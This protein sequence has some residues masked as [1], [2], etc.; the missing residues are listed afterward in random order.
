MLIQGVPLATEPSISLIILTPIWRAGFNPVWTQM[1]ATCSTYYDVV[2]FLTTNVLLFKFRCN[3]FIGVRIIEEMPGSVASGTPCKRVFLPQNDHYCYCLFLAVAISWIIW[4][5]QN[6]ITMTNQTL[7]WSIYICIQ[8]VYDFFLIN[9]TQKIGLLNFL[10]QFFPHKLLPACHMQQSVLCKAQ[11]LSQSRNSSHFMGPRVHNGLLLVPVLSQI[12]ALHALPID[13]FKISSNVTLPSE[14]RSSKWPV[15]LWFPHQNPRLGLPSGLF[16]SGFHTKT[17]Y[18]PL[19][20]PRHDTFPAH[21]II[22]VFI[23]WIIFNGQFKSWTSLLC[24]FFQS[25]V[26]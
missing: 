5:V 13:F 14:T 8:A 10:S 19:L 16:I 6:L 3:I 17:L 12:S 1:V 25:P 22:P 24:I 20:S 26:I 23:T 18:V 15:Y 11:F 21:L 7:H 9:F 2:T 4:K